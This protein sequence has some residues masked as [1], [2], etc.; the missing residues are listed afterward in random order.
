MRGL[1]VRIAERLRGDRRIGN[2]TTA[3][4]PRAGGRF[5]KEFADRPE[6]TRSVRP[7]APPAEV[8]CS[9]LPC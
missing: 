2:L 7:E 8:R 6:L 9:V 3:T 1:R 5:M 4:K